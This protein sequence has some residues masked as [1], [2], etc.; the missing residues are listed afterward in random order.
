MLI[1]ITIMKFSCSYATLYYRSQIIRKIVVNINQI[2][3]NILRYK[4]NK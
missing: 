1:R 4:T 3:F 2:Y